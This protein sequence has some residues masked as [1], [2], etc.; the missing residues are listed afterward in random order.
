MNRSNASF[1]APEATGMGQPLN[2][3]V[4]PGPRRQPET[5]SMAR[6]IQRNADLRRWF[7]HAL[8]TRAQRLA[9]QCDVPFVLDPSLERPTAGTPRGTSPPLDDSSHERARPT[10]PPGP[11]GG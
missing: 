8:P 6:Y 3:P 2:L 9:A 7:A 1:D 5:L 10:A 4:A 11:L